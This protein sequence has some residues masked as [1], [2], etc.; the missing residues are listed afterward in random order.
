MAVIQRWLAYRGWSWL[1]HR[2]GL[3]IEVVIQRWLAYRGW[4]WLLH[5]VVG[6]TQMTY[7]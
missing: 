6:Y 5:R 4:S 1:L 3:L 2:G 7:L